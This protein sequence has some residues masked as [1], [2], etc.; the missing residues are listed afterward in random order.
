MP[1]EEHG[2][3]FAASKM[4]WTIARRA[5]TFAPSYVKA[6]PATAGTGFMTQVYHLHRLADRAHE[7]N[8]GSKLK[9]GDFSVE[10]FTLPVETARRKVRDI[11]ARVPQRGQSGIVERWRQL[12]DGQIRFTMRIVDVEPD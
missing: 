3:L 5:P 12:P 8:N 9:D 4:E 11:I 6:G 10:T 7:Q 1:R 2:L